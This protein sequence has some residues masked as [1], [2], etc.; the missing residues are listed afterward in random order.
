MQ[1]KTVFNPNNKGHVDSTYPLFLGEQLGLYNSIHVVYPEL[2][3]LYKKQRSFTWTEDEINLE[4]DRLLMVHES[5]KQ[6]DIDLMVKNIALLWELDSVAS[7]SI[8]SMFA[9]FITNSELTALMTETSRMEVIHALTYSEIV[10]QCVPDP[11]K[12]IN[13]VIENDNVLGRSDLIINSFNDL[14]E[15]GS[16]YNLGEVPKDKKLRKAILK[17]LFSLLL[18]ERVQFYG[19]FAS[20]FSFGESGRFIGIS[21]LV[22]LV[23]RDEIL[24][25]TM[26]IKILQILRKDTEWEEAFLESKPDIEALVEEVIQREF[27]WGEYIFSEGRTTLGLNA[28]ILKDWTL[29][30]VRDVVLPF[31]LNVAHTLPTKNPIPWID[32]WLDVSSTQV[33]PQEA[34]I[35]SYTVNNVV[36]DV[37]DDEIFEI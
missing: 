7:R 34:E 17:G 22:S 18:L 15:L 9:P 14:F 37:K 11:Q 3:E 21:K 24:H 25:A 32:N 36:N 31:G 2:F 19:S 4:H 35:V 29:Y 8:I 20:I 1:K 5:T 12:A 28:V 13:E 23:A 26:V 16:R 6:S 30:C 27:K 33:A 10:R